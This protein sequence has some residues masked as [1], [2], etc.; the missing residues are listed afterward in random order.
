LADHLHFG[1]AAAV[2]R[3]AQPQLSNIVQRIEAGLGFALF[4]RKPRV[5]L[6]SEGAVIAAAARGAIQD[7]DAAVARATLLAAGETGCVRVGLAS[8]ALLTPL[9]GLLANFRT[10]NP[11]V[12]VKLVDLHSADQAPAL[13]SGQIDLAIGRQDD[14]DSRFHGEI[15]FEEPFVAIVPET[16]KLAEAID[17]SADELRG[18]PLILFPE[19]VAP[20]LYEQIRGILLRAGLSPEPDQEVKE[21]HSI[22]GLV[23]NGFGVSLAP[24]SVKALAG[25]GVVCLPL[26]DE[27]TLACLR[28]W[29]LQGATSSLAASLG[30]YLL[31]LAGLSAATD[32]L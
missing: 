14:L 19:E 15:V 24:R 10:A 12:L 18:Q 32:R 7:M 29:R 3:M 30:E 13:L 16:S 26:R 4:E 28:L 1:R 27:P 21:W 23:R 8:T 25:K 2:L 31:K 5:R 9:L 20:S 17:I 11:K 6:T 22:V